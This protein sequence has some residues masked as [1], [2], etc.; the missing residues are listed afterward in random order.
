MWAMTDR[1]TRIFAP[2]QCSTFRARSM[3]LINYFNVNTQSHISSQLLAA[4][5]VKWQQIQMPCI[6]HHVHHASSSRSLLDS[7]CGL[8]PRAMAASADCHI[9]CMRRCSHRGRAG[10]GHSGEEGRN[11]WCVG[12]TPRETGQS[13]VTDACPCAMRRALLKRHQRSLL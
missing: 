11:V 3:S 5:R 9:C 8:L 12:R 13:A 2:K 1:G 4:A 6:G 7:A 10:L